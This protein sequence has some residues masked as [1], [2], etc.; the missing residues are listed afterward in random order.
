MGDA[1]YFARMICKA[2]HAALDP[3]GLVSVTMP[4]VHGFPNNFE[5]IPRAADSLPAWRIYEPAGRAMVDEMERRLE[6]AAGDRRM[7]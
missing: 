6:K 5:P 4:R 2:L 3:D 7:I 1:E